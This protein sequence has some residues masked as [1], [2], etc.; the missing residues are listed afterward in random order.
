MVAPEDRLVLVAEV[1][2]SQLSS[3][4]MCLPRCTAD[5]AISRDLKPALR[6]L[7]RCGT[8]G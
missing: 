6:P 1:S 5:G 8:I 7:R 2:L 3:V 4:A